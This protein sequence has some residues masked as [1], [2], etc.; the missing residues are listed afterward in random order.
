[1]ALTCRYSQELQY[2][3]YKTKQMLKQTYVKLY[4]KNK[5]GLYLIAIQEPFQYSSSITWLV[6]LERLMVDLKVYN[7]NRMNRFMI[8]RPQQMILD[9]ANLLESIDYL[10]KTINNQQDFEYK[11]CLLVNLKDGQG[12]GSQ[13]N[14]LKVRH[15]SSNLILTNQILDNIN[16]HILTY[17]QHN[18]L[19]NNIVILI[20][21][22][23]VRNLITSCYP[24]QM[25]MLKRNEDEK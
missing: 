4:I 14:W 13:T 7:L 19:L 11:V 6:R 9:V 1:M 12:I 18:N 20:N 16:Q 10:K 2:F 22:D 21:L 3:N 8:C 15:T 5:L 24:I 23:I 25:A 17:F